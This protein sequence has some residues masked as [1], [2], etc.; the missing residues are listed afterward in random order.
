VPDSIAWL[1]IAT[2]ALALA[3]GA[4][5][6]RRRTRR[7]GQRPGR[8]SPTR[9]AAPGRPRPP[10][11]RASTRTASRAPAKGARPATTKPAT[12]ATTGPQARE[13]WWAD[14]PFHDAEGSK[15]RP[16]LVLRRRGDTVVVLKI[17][18]QDHRD[19]G[20]HILIETSSWDRGAPHDSFLDLS[21]PYTISAAAFE[22]KVGRADDAT[23]KTVR[24][25]HKVD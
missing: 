5:A 21:D 15:V 16:C 13:I 24:A 18:S 19:R 14:V 25:Q 23:W 22:D 10:T 17:T 12:P 11:S 6:L 3:A 20:D 7:P 9:P 2:A 8:P 1:L 4:A